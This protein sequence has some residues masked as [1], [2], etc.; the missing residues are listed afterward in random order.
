MSFWLLIFSEAKRGKNHRDTEVTEG[1]EREVG[2]D[3]VGVCSISKSTELSP[4]NSPFA[5]KFEMSRCAY[6]A[7][8]GRTSGTRNISAMP[9]RNRTPTISIAGRWP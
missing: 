3:R 5:R 1:R 2:S 7:I 6:S 4:T 8:S 9:T